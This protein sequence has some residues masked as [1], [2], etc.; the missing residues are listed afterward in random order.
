MVRLY[1]LLAA[2]SEATSGVLLSVPDTGPCGP[3][4]ALLLRVFRPK[5]R[6]LRFQLQAGDALL[7]GTDMVKDE[8]TLLAAYDDSDG[9]TAAF[10]LNILRRLNREL[11]ANFDAGRFC[12]RVFWNSS[13]SRIEMHLES[14]RKQDVS[15]K[16]AG[17][18]LRFMPCETIHTENSYKFT[19]TGI[20]SLLSAAISG[21]TNME[22]QPQL[23]CSDARESEHGSRNS[24]QA[25]WRQPQVMFCGSTPRFLERDRVSSSV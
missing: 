17:L 23:V 2:E 10:N 9:V 8:A 1:R 15:I 16:D 18:E 20:G 11:G 7:L 14:T 3:R 22:G 21:N 19:D 12:H 24:S 5:M 13:E 25:I 4:Q 6:D